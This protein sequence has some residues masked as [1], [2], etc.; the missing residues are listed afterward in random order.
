MNI[1]Q[2]YQRYK[3]RHIGYN[4]HY[5]GFREWY[6]AWGKQTPGKYGYA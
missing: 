2:R 5:M 1:R 6:N 4:W 3:I